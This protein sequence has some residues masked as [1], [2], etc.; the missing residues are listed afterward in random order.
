MTNT[1][2]I[3]PRPSNP[4]EIS[5]DRRC[6]VQDGEQIEYRVSRSSL[7]SG[8]AKFGT[9]RAA[10]ESYARRT[11]RPVTEHRVPI[12]RRISWQ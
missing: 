11:G 8:P 2:N 12:M 10:A 1:T 6:F 7:H 9:D 4:S 5:F 3:G